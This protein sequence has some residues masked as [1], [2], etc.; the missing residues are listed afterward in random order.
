MLYKIIN[1]KV[2]LPSIPIT[3]MESSLSDLCDFIKEST[4]PFAELIHININFFPIKLWNNLSLQIANSSSFLT[5]KNL[6]DKYTIQE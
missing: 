6:L 4:Y 3:R 2:S 1:N 5:F